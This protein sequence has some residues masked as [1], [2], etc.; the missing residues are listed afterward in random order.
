MIISIDIVIASLAN[1]YTSHIAII[2]VACSLTLHV[3]KICSLHNTV[4]AP[5]PLCIK[6][7]HVNRGLTE[8][9]AESMIST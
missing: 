7:G 6:L 8:I 2:S 5:W 3:K 1:Y 4:V 9:S